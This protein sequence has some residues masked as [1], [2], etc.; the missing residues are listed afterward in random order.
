MCY[1][2]RNVSSKYKNTNNLDYYDDLSFA[3]QYVIENVIVG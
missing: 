3:I 1:K 2:L